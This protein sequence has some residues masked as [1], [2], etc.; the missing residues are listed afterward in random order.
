MS[1]INKISEMSL[2]RTD[3]I[4]LLLTAVTEK[5]AKNGKPYCELSLSDGEDEIT[6]RIFDKK[7]EDI[8]NESAEMTAVKVSVKPQIFNGQTSYLCSDFRKAPAGTDMNMFRKSAKMPSEEMFTDIVEGPVFDEK[9]MAKINRWEKFGG[10]PRFIKN[11]DLLRLVTEIYRKNRDAILKSAAAKRN[12]HAYYGGLL[13][14]TYR[15]LISA[16]ALGVIYRDMIDM[17]VLLAA[18]AL[19]DI[20]KIAELETTEL[21]VADYTVTGSMLG[22]TVIGITMVEKE[23]ME[24]AAAGNPYTETEKILLVKHCIAAH[25]GTKEWGAAALPLIPEAMVLH[26]VDMIDANMKEFQDAYRK[27]EPGQMTQD[28]VPAFN[29]QV[30]RASDGN[31]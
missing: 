28:R 3:D 21:G 5:V 25:H 13:D 14:H 10:L 7:K 15:M 20:G 27:A 29:R 11:P 26:Q 19:H 24:A 12:H 8:V 16:S 18:T 9:T 1:K 22:H 6:A 4:I 30:Y 17:D 2:D 23:V 31:A